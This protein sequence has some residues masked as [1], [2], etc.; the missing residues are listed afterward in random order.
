MDETVLCLDF[1]VSASFQA[2]GPRPWNPCGR[3]S[4][5]ARPRLEMGG[6]TADT[7]EATD[8]LGCGHMGP[9]TLR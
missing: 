4:L 5:A 3:G 8:G 9:L 6:V 7:E 2:R 1:C